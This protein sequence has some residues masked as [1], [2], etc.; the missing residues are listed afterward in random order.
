[1]SPISTTDLGGIEA[2]ASWVNILTVS[3]TVG[4]LCQ[5]WHP[6]WRFGPSC[7]LCIAKNNWLVSRHMLGHCRSQHCVSTFSIF[8]LF[9]LCTMEFF[10]TYCTV[11][12]S[13]SLTSSPR[14]AGWVDKF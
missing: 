11:S 5:T 4:A 8:L 10:E 7:S 6:S 1:L 14:M 2:T 13:S 3:W 12:S 9:Y